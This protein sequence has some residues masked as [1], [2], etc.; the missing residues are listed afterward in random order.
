MM[1]FEKVY[2]LYVLETIFVHGTM[3]LKA[4]VHGVKESAGGGGGAQTPPICNHK[5]LSRVSEPVHVVLF[6]LQDDI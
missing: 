3:L 1:G 2:N 4:S 6:L 5:S